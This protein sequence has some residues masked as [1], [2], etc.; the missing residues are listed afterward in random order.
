MNATRIQTGMFK[1][2]MEMG[3]IE[4]LGRGGRVISRGAIFTATPCRLLLLQLYSLEMVLHNIAR[5]C[6][7]LHSIVASCCCR[8][9]ALKSA[10]KRHNQ[11]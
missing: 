8:F 10:K 9:T 7:V 3:V 1:V 2:F 6:M 4:G 11:L 5:Y